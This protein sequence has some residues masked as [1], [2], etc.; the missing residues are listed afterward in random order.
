MCR[1]DIE[2]SNAIDEGE[3]IVICNSTRQLEGDHSDGD[4][5]SS[6]TFRLQDGAGIN[7]IA[8]MDD[9]FIWTS[10]GASDI[11]QWKSPPRRSLRAAHLLEKNSPIEKS[12]RRASGSSDIH[13]SRANLSIEMSLDNNVSLHGYPSGKHTTA[14]SSQYDLTAQDEQTLYGIP[15]NSLVKLTSPTDS[16]IGGG[17]R[18]QGRREA[19]VA[20]LYSAASIKSIPTFGIRPGTSNVSPSSPSTNSFLYPMLS[21]VFISHHTEMNSSRIEYEHRDLAAMAVPLEPEPDAVIQGE[22]GIVRSIVLNDRMHALTI[23]TSGC[24][25]VW[26]IIR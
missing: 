8:V 24:I 22:H 19:D 6:E 16:Y 11:K 12:S 5:S 2:G 25:A 15:Y 18:S 14:L 20:T 3:C 10:A 26:D 17:Y 13:S 23:D 1:V 9:R 21:P 7:S 4:G